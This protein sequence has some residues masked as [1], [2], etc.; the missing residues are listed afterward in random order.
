M[1]KKIENKETLKEWLNYELY[2]IYGK[3][4][5][6]KCFLVD[7]FKLSEASILRK[8]I[9]LLRMTE[10]YINSNK[11]IRALIY[12]CRLRKFQNK[13]AIHVPPNTC[14]KGLHLMH[15]GPI[16]FNGKAKVGENCTFHINTALVAGGTNDG[17]PMLGN[18]IILGVGA[19]VVG[20]VTIA[21]GVAVG[22]NALVNRD[23]SEINITVAGVP[24]RKVSDKG[25]LDWNRR[26]KEGKANSV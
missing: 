23:V 1:Y 26:N 15:V 2:E 5:T 20:G 4:Q 7:F 14:G 9:R 12:S 11:K 25:R 16:L 18:N 8:H 6:I 24:A 3:K 17:T 13:Y 19:V 10:Y 22:A 21:D